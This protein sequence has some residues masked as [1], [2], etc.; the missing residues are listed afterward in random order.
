MAHP[1]NNPSALLEEDSN[2]MMDSLPV[3]ESTRVLAS[4]DEEGDSLPG[5]P[6]FHA[7]VQRRVESLPTE[8]SASRAQPEDDEDD[9]RDEEEDEDGGEE[10]DEDDE[11]ELEE[12]TLDDDDFFE[13][14]PTGE[15]EPDDDDDEEEDDSLLDE[16]L[17]DGDSSLVTDPEDSVQGG[18]GPHWEAERALKE[19]SARL[20]TATDM[21]DSA[22]NSGTQ[23]P[24]SQGRGSGDLKDEPLPKPKKRGRPSRAEM[25]ERAQARLRA[26]E[27]PGGDVPSD[28]EG[29][30]P[31]PKKSRRRGARKPVELDENGLPVIKRRGR[32][33]MPP[34][35]KAKIKEEKRLQRIEE[36]RRKR[37]KA[38][39]EAGVV[40]GRGQGRTKRRGRRAKVLSD[41]DLAERERVR[42]L[43]YEEF[44]QQKR[45]KA[46][47]RL[48]RNAALREFRRKKKEEEKKQRE[49]YEKRMQ[50]LRASFLDENSHMS[51]LGGD[52]SVLIDES[53]MQSS[54]SK[55]PRWALGN[56]ELSQLKQIKQVSAETLFEYCWP[57]GGRVSEYYFLQEQVTEYLAIKSFK[58]KYPHCTRRN[59]EAEERDFL[60]EMRIVNE[61]QADLGLTAIPA[62]QVLDIMSQDFY[63]K[64]DEYMTVKSER[65][66]RLNRQTN[67]STV[68]IEKHKF[69]DFVEKAVKSA[70]DWN[71]Q[72]NQ[73]KKDKRRAYF[74]MQTFIIQRPMNNRGR[75]KVLQKPKLG[76]YPVALIPGQ[77][78]DYYKTLTPEQ[79]A[80]LPL[81]T[82]LRG[83]PPPQVRLG[84]IGSDGKTSD[85][86][87]SSSSASSSDESSSSD[88]DSDSDSGDSSAEAET[89]E[90]SDLKTEGVQEK[91]G[92]EMETDE[93]DAGKPAQPIDA[94]IP[95]ASCK[96]C[97]GDRQRNKIGQPEKLLHCSKCSQSCHPTCAGLT[98]ELLDYVTKYKW[99]CTEC[100]V[101]SL[102]QDHSDEDKML[103]CDLCDRGYHNYCVG[104]DTIPSGRWQ[105]SKCTVC[106]S[107][108]VR[109]SNGTN[110][111]QSEHRWV[112]EFKTSALS[113]N[114]VY[115][116]AMCKPCHRAW[117]R[118]QF[119]PECTVAFGR[120][121]DKAEEDVEYF[122]CWVCSR[123]HHSACVGQP[124][125]ICGACQKKTLEKSLGAV[126]RSASGPGP[127]RD[128]A[129]MFCGPVE[130]GNTP[131]NGSTRRACLEYQPVTCD[132]CQKVYKNKS[133]LYSHKN[134]D[135]GMKASIK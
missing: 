103:F 12:I 77:F 92:V 70:A 82:T 38:K 87:S 31:A 121:P 130:R 101:C 99:M 29:G 17:L 20:K 98:L 57:P 8:P 88:D 95:G 19:G 15:D 128:L 6:S 22:T 13:D 59:V 116:H 112:Y 78:V 125:F 72:L 71:K 32:K 115:S 52:D 85:H 89:P 49:E 104:L 23:S 96:V 107:C 4:G 14:P 65:K 50:N 83:P 46:Q 18:S 114:K 27:P 110:V 3:A 86:E 118:G 36:R 10:E 45:E 54:A 79:L 111:L 24:A 9:D 11:D 124:T 134:R 60:V 53:S 120:E 62:T 74:D 129:E 119:C 28:P 64:Y 44:K 63:E 97:S 108:N 90:I 30:P 41:E 16:T 21:V 102:C 37:L 131:S 84:D 94:D 25:L 7:G 106:S 34:E 42:K 5:G 58:R 67:Y 81:N 127:V 133:T 48:E 117:K 75:M 39:E 132:V 91:T 51:G 109:D 80:Y 55:L 105:C 113:G 93:D 68:T 47:Q 61:T 40:S 56:H 2:A 35:M 66:D 69:A 135:H 100:K 73:D 33:P 26:Q 76:S 123:Q 1:S 43:K 122:Y 126:H